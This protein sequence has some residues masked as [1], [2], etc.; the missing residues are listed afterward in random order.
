MK[1]VVVERYILRTALLGICFGIFV[2]EFFSIGLY[3]VLFSLLILTASVLLT[4]IVKMEIRVRPLLVLLSVFLLAIV[5]GVARSAHSEKEF[6]LPGYEGETLT[7]YGGVAREP[8][9]RESYLSL[10]VD[11]G[12]L[13][14]DSECRIVSEKVIVKADRFLDASYGDEVRV[15]GSLEVPKPFTTETGRTFSYD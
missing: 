10:V 12:T 9:T 2:Y 4:F 7:L 8:E 11:V 15:S 14:T 6:I 13:E 5:L 1:G 3:A